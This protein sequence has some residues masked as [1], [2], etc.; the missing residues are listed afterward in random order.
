VCGQCGAGFTAFGRPPLVLRRLPP[1]RLAPPAGS[2][3]PHPTRQDRHRLR[4]PTMPDPLP[5]HPTLRRLQHLVPA[6]RPG[7]TM[8][9]LWWS[10]GS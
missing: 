10:C 4:M 1:I 7:R 3:P 9:P 5:R 2:T 6:P 8:P